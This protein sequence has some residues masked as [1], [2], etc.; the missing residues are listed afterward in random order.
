M[1]TVRLRLFVAAAHSIADRAS[2]P[3]FEADIARPM[4]RR[5]KR[6]STGA[7]WSHPSSVRGNFTPVTLAAA[8]HFKHAAERGDGKVR[9]L[10]MKEREPHGLCF[11]KNF[12]AVFRISRSISSCLFSRRRRASSA[13]FVAGERSERRVACNFA[14]TFVSALHPVAQRS[15]SLI[16]I[17]RDTINAAVAC[18]AQAYRLCF[19]LR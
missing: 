16:Q 18:L 19:E 3:S 6:S 5:E 13:T 2:A 4:T 7:T 1:R 12:A 9:A 8:R 10:D 17:F 15:L 14:C 11:A